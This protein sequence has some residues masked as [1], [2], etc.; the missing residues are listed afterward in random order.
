MSTTALSEPSQTCPLSHQL[1][2]PMSRSRTA[3]SDV[4]AAGS[5]HA[6][7]RLEQVHYSMLANG[8][9]RGDFR[10][11]L[12]KSLYR[13]GAQVELYRVPEPR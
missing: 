11:W 6:D 10:D 9:Y 12:K 4:R 1:R 2:G 7:G 3:C 13:S 8:L 5:R